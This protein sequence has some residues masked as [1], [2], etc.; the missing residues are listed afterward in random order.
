[1]TAM[2][3]SN[4]IAFIC[5]LWLCLLITR[6]TNKAA[7]EP[8][9]RDTIVDTITVVKPVAKDSVVTR[10]KWVNVERVKDTTIVNE[11]SEVVFD[12]IQVRLPIESKHYTSINYDAWVSG[13]EPALD[14]IKVYSREVVVKPK[15]SRW[16]VGLQGGV[17][18]TPKGLQ[19]YVGIGVAYKLK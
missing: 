18:M 8:T 17:G 19:P 4:I 3:L 13:Y 1:M 11:V 15:K 6:C 12:T 5:G 7:T 2:K 9:L 14:S 16:S 10:Y